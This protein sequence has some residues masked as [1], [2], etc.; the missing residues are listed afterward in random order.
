ME[1]FFS[2]L[3]AS[4]L[5]LVLRPLSPRQRRQVSPTPIHIICNMSAAAKIL[6]ENA[7]ELE[8]QVGQALIDLENSAPE[9]KSSLRLIQLKSVR[10]V[11]ILLSLRTKLRQY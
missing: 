10:E 2:S 9:Q 5:P 3:V 11:S 4:P 1:F 7:T 6:H 8:L